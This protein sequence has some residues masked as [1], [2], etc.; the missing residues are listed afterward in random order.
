MCKALFAYWRCIAAPANAD[1]QPCRP[2]HPPVAQTCE[3]DQLRQLVH[4]LCPSI[5]GHELVKVGRPF[6]WP[7]V[8]I[9]VAS[10][11]P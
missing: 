3:G 1:C 10:Q 2:I 4:S 7:C 9:V 8:A 5:F 6:G 11:V